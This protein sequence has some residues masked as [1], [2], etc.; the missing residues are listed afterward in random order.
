MKELNSNKWRCGA[1]LLAALATAGLSSCSGDDL[2]PW[3]MAR[4]E[5][6]QAGSTSHFDYSGGSLT[7]NVKSNTDWTVAVPDWVEV[8][9]ASGTG[10]A[11]LTF[12]VLEN[13]T[14]DDRSGTIAVTAR[15]QSQST[16]AGR[17]QQVVSVSQTSILDHI[18]GSIEVTDV[19]YTKEITRHASYIYYDYAYC[20][21]TITFNVSSP[22]S[23]EE[24]SQYVKNGR[25][26]VDSPY[27]Y[28]LFT[29][30]NGANTIEFS[31]D[32]FERLNYTADLSFS[33]ADENNRY[34]DIVDAKFDNVSINVIDLTD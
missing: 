33:F 17:A 26:Y 27:G 18:A 23:D 11:T 19:K 4:M 15:Q 7:L 20:D 25:V 3:E 2:D 12:N 5:L 9:K 22:F 28:H 24:L 31:D 16:V 32:E 1:V 29:L 30:K 8:D 21:H 6:S 14:T 10:D 34:Y 13:L